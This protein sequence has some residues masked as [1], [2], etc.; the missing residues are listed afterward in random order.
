MQL[1]QL[2]IGHLLQQQLDSREYEWN[3]RKQNDERSW[4]HDE[5]LELQHTWFICEYY[6]FLCVICKKFKQKEKKN[7][8]TLTKVTKM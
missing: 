6:S 3:S 8:M 7:N 5:I 4:R 2:E 1:L